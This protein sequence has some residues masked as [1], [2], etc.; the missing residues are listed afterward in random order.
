MQLPV[1][2][3]ASWSSPSIVRTPTGAGRGRERREGRAAGTGVPPSLGLRNKPVTVNRSK[4][5]AA[6]K[7]PE[8]F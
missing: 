1:C 4:G 5:P 6:V 8:R 2:R 7:I 3:S